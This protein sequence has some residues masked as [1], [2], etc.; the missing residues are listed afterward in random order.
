MPLTIQH[1]C[2]YNYKGKQS[3]PLSGL[4]KK[5]RQYWFNQVSN[6]QWSSSHCLRDDAIEQLTEPHGAKSR[7]SN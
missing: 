2:N 6:K 7:R 4:L 5:T 3:L 1:K